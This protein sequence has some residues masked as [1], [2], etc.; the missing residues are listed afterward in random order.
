MN[1]ITRLTIGQADSLNQ[2]ILTL[3]DKGFDPDGESIRSPNL[4]VEFQGERI[5]F[6]LDGD[7]GI[8]HG[9][10]D[11]QGHGIWWLRRTYPPTLNRI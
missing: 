10:L 8:A 5:I 2:I 3:H 4:H 6:W 7:Q 9:S 1:D 11:R